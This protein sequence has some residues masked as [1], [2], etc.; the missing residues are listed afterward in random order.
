MAKQSAVSDPARRG[1]AAPLVVRHPIKAAALLYSAPGFV[2]RGP[3]YMMFVSMFAMLG[4]SI[5]ATTSTLVTVPVKLQRESVTVQAIGGGII[6][7]LQV[8]ENSVV[9]PGS[10]LAIVQE[11]IR[12]AATPEQEAIDRQ[13]RDLEE[14]VKAAKRDYEFRKSQMES[15]LREATDRQTTGRSTLENRLGQLKNQ[16]ATLQRNRGNL[17]D[18]LANAQRK[19]AELRP[20]CERRDLPRSACDQQEQQVSNLRRAVTTA[21]TDIDSAK[22]SIASAETE[23]KMMG[24][25]GSLER[26]QAD[27]DKLDTDFSERSRQFEKQV[28]DLELRRR[29]SQT[30]V[31]GLRYGMS[32]ADRDKAYYSSTDDGI[33]TTVH[34]QPGQL[35]Q[36]GAQVVTFVKNTAPLEARVLAPNKDIGQLKVGQ[37]VQLKYFAYPFQEWGIQSGTIREISTRPSTLPGEESLYVVNVSLEHEKIRHPTKN[38]EKALEIGLQGM[39]EIKTGERR[40]IEIMFSPAAKFFHG[41]D[42]EDSEAEGGES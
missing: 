39:A 8:R 37:H 6:E 17:D 2:L 3:I 42:S 23:L 4:Y 38:I 26:L 24:D 28:A 15:Q 7:Q 9:R 10:A 25:A 40:F 34:V 14:Q 31:P 19:L 36:P 33:V 27:L 41:G 32:D 11:K 13:V 18:D 30:L 1:A 29:Q 22:L 20:L 35:I 16:L 5:V 21:L 12:A